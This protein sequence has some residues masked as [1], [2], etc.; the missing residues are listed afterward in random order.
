MLVI[1]MICRASWLFL[2]E[3]WSSGLSELM[4]RLSRLEKARSDDT[5]NGDSKSSKKGTN[6]NPAGYPARHAARGVTMITT[7][8]RR[9][10]PQALHPIR[11][12]LWISKMNLAANGVS[13]HPCRVLNVFARK[14]HGTET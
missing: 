11:M 13:S 5:G 12:L 9:R 6:R 2:G 7:V 4:D 3:L 14:F 1:R 8:L 10:L